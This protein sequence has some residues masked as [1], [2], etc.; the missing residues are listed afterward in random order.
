MLV[1]DS[2]CGVLETDNA[3]GFVRL[4]SIEGVENVL[5]EEELSDVGC[6]SVG[7]ESTCSDA[8]TNVTCNVNVGCTSRIPPWKDSSDPN[9][10]V[11]ITGLKTTVE[12]LALY[13]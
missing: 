2:I 5:R 8:S 9:D 4:E 10:T 13:M 12:G 1:V 11:V 7:K 3:V 6:S